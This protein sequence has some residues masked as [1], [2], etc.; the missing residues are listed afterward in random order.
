MENKDINRW[1]KWVWIPRDI[2]LAKNLS[3]L[4]KMLLVEIDSLDNEEWCFAGNTYFS[5]FFG[6]SEKHIST[7]ISKLKEEWCILEE[8]FNGRQR[9]LKS[10]MDKWLSIAEKRAFTKSSKQPL[11]NGNSSIHQMVKQNNIDNNI[12]NNI[13]NNINILLS[14]KNSDTAPVVI[15]ESSCETQNNNLFLEISTS[16]LKE[17]MPP[18]RKDG[19]TKPKSDTKAKTPA[20]S[21]TKWENM[22]LQWK[23]PYNDNMTDSAAIVLYVYDTLKEWKWVLIEDIS[24]FYWQVCWFMR[25]W[26][27]LESIIKA[28]WTLSHNDF[29]C[30][31]KVWYDFVWNFSYLVSKWI[32]YSIWTKIN[33]IDSETSSVLREKLK[34]LVVLPS[35][36]KDSLNRQKSTTPTYEYIDE[37][38][39]DWTRSPEEEEEIRRKMRE[40]NN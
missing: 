25:K 35:E 20:I 37:P 15:S 28:M 27:K 24:K 13:D 14:E 36:Y 10:L 26:V 2:W 34:Y 11:P 22:V 21:F 6:V 9:K 1:F 32:D 39:E 33:K 18:K 40:N 17:K 30:G 29:S 4:Q 12:K 5:I 16:V 31:E 7:S 19:S 38:D 23:R 3:L 8:S